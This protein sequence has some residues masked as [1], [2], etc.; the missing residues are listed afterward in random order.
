MKENSCN[1]LKYFLSYGDLTNLEIKEGGSRWLKLVKRNLFYKVL[2][3]GEL[4]EWT[5]AISE[6]GT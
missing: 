1:F 3:L 5:T 6:A 2:T 4:A